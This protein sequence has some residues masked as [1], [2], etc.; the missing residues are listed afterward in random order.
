MHVNKYKLVI[1]QDI[2]ESFANERKS[3]VTALKKFAI[4]KPML[5]KIE[6]WTISTSASWAGE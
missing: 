2:I 6:I 4:N 3:F 5:H 1:S